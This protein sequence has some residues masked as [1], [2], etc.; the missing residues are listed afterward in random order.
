MAGDDRNRNGERQG[1]PEPAPH[2]GFHLLRHPRVGHG[3][4]VIV[5]GAC[6]VRPRY[7][8][9]L[10]GAMLVFGP[11][12]GGCGRVMVMIVG[13]VVMRHVVLQR[14]MGPSRR[15]QA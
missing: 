15:H 4:G 2:V 3:G 5:M 7:R 11:R 14:N 1:D 10:L 8:W 13:V 9:T 6:R 12:R